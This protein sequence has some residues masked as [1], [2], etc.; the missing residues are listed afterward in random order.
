VI[1]EKVIPTPHYIGSNEYK[2]RFGHNSGRRIIITD[3]DRRAR[4][5][6]QHTEAVLEK[7]AQFVLITTFDRVNVDTVLTEPIWYK[8]GSDEPVSLLDG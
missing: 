7:M 3:G 4:K 2:R 6:K 5:L 1:Y 8:G